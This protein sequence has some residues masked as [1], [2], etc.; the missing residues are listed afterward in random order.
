M[1]DSE[2]RPNRRGACRIEADIPARQVPDSLSFI[3]RT[4]VMT[5]SDLLNEA[6]RRQ[7]SPFDQTVVATLGD[8]TVELDLP[9]TPRV[10]MFRKAEGGRR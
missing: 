9:A 1:G 2:F 6:S 5:V 7:T 3:K 10:E 8:S 4:K